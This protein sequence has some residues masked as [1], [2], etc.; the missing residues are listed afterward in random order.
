MRPTLR[1]VLE[2]YRLFNAWELEEEKRELPQLR[3]DESLAQ[4]FELCALAQALAPDS[5]QVFL[6]LDKAHWMALRKRL[7]RAAEVMGVAPPT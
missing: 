3:V 2:A 1:E 6:E 7:K 5:A 4:F